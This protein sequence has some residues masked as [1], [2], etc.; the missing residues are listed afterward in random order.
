MIWGGIDPG[1]KGGFAFVSSSNE[2]MADELPDILVFDKLLKKHKPNIKHLYLE[3]ALHMP[4]KGAE[5]QGAKSRFNYGESYGMIRGV[6][7][8][9]EIPHSLVHPL[10]WQFLAEKQTQQK[11]T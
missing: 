10:T 8:A 7:I 1:K 4:R 11:A 2:V 9:N 3:K 6:L 5:K